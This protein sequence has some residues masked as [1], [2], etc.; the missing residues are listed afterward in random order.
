MPIKVALVDDHNLFRSGIKSLIKHFKE[1]EIILE[2]SNGD[3][4]IKKLNSGEKPEVLFLDLSMPVMDGVSTAKWLHTFEPGIKTII[5]S[6]AE[7]E[8]TVLTLLKHGI[9][10]YLLKDSEPEEFKAALDTVAA[11]RY[12]YPQFVTE[13]MMKQLQKPEADVVSSKTELNQRELEF[14]KYIAT[15]LTYKEIA[16]EMSVSVRTIDNYRDSLFEKLQV[17]SR[18]GLALYAVKNNLT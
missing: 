1:Y 3:D 8:K 4:F 6:M 14:L 15:E 10:G 2:A 9:K 18:V 5:L 13:H 12:Y 17:K 7:D 11:G 16:D